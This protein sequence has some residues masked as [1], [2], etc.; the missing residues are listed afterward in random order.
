MS[1]KDTLSS[2]DDFDFGGL[3]RL[4]FGIG[5]GGGCDETGA[6]GGAGSADGIVSSSSEP[7][8]TRLLGFAS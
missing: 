5:A 2:V 4:G 3:P 8:A 1:G 6:G 7:A